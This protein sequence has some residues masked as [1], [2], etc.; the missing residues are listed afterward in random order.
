MRAARSMR[1]I[2][3]MQMS[4]SRSVSRVQTAR[5]SQGR[6]DGGGGSSGWRRH[7]V[8]VKRRFCV[9]VFRA[10]APFAALLCGSG[11]VPLRAEFLVPLCDDG[12][13]AA[14]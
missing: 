8:G 9:V 2:C 13:R 6:R 10:A 14:V 4:V 1:R 5:R 7:G 11:A 12:G 3:L